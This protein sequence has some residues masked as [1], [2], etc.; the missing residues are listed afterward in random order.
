MWGG[1]VTRDV[2]HVVH[3]NAVAALDEPGGH[4]T[5]NTALGAGDQDP[6]AAAGC[7]DPLRDHCRTAWR[8]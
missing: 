2:D 1:Q 6:H 3:A 8:P 7:P 4:A 5:A